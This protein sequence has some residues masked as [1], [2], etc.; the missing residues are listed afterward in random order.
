MAF[1]TPENFSSAVAFG[2][3]VCYTKT[4]TASHGRPVFPPARGRQSRRGWFSDL[5]PKTF[6]QTVQETSL[7]FPA[8]TL[9]FRNRRAPGIPLEA[10]VSTGPLYL[11]SGGV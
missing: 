8:H 10:G 4:A 1:A 7:R 6:I 2:V 9:P 5:R 11:K 3:P